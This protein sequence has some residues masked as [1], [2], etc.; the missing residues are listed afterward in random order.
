MRLGFLFAFAIFVA[1][2]SA[3]DGEERRSSDDILVLGE[4]EK[5]QRD[6]IRDYVR[7]LS[8][9]GWDS[10]MTRFDAVCPGVIGLP[11]AHRSAIVARIRAVAASA[12]IKVQDEGC[13]PNV[14][15]IVIPDKAEMLTLLRKK[16]S[17]L[18]RS[19]EGQSLQVAKEDGPV[20][21]WHITQKLA[22]GG[23]TATSGADVTTLTFDGPSPRVIAAFRPVSLATMILIEQRGLVGLT[24]MQ[25]AD[26]AAMR[27]FTTISP[28]RLSRSNA[29]TIL[30][31]MTSEIG[32]ETPLS[33]TRWDHAFLKGAYAV[34]PFSYSSS[35][36]S[37]IRRD[38]DREL[39]DKDGD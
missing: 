30:R 20:T 9:E 15:I 4:R 6:Q 24:T 8:T 32:E 2:A 18:F 16:H 22:R 27:A 3:Q 28:Q 21:A 23:L 1:P 35:Q 38:I 11:P 34:S 33:L 29:P 5:G 13:A 10:P 12:N 25:I 19:Y 26:Y 14:R 36:R 37:R 31:V 39:N 17:D 7:A